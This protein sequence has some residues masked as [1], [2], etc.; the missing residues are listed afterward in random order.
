[1]LQ[2]Y[3]RKPHERGR[4]T[5]PFGIDTA[6][7]YVR[8]GAFGNR[9]ENASFVSCYASPNEPV[10]SEKIKHQRPKGRMKRATC[11][12][13]VSQTAF[14]GRPSL[15]A[16]VVRLPFY[17]FFSDARVSIL[18]TGF[19]F[20]VCQHTTLR[21]M[22]ILVWSFLCLIS[23]LFY[24]T[25]SPSGSFT[26]YVSSWGGG[27]GAFDTNVLSMGLAFWL[28]GGQKVKFSPDVI[29]ECSLR[30][31]HSPSSS[32]DEYFSCALRFF[33]YKKLH[34]WKKRNDPF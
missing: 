32:F 21:Y 31:P 26:N 18:V 34:V 16:C 19:C 22:L 5:A 14:K 8:K 23:T 33:V 1:M 12:P 10:V 15:S 7:R 6:N 4:N 30:W 17:D 3:L 25:L 28:G 27:L 11:R 24:L 20:K 9:G 29:C 13:A 2:W